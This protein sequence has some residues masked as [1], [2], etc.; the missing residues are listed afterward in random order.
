MF[1]IIINVFIELCWTIM[2][3]SISIS[4]YSVL[5]CKY[6]DDVLIDAPYVLT[7]EII[8]SLHISIVLTANSKYAVLD[9]VYKSST[10]NTTENG[11]STINKN[12]QIFMHTDSFPIIK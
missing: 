8:Q 7:K 5:G 1:R 3:K 12:E 9:T 11:D 6:V 4:M 10:N 2:I